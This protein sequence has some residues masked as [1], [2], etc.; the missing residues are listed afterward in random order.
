MGIG[1]V[2]RFKLQDDALVGTLTGAGY[3][4]EFR[5]ERWEGAEAAAA[6]RPRRSR[7]AS[8][9]RRTGSRTWRSSKNSCRR[10]HCNWFD[11]LP[12]EKWKAAVDALWGDFPSLTPVQMVVRMAQ[13]V[14][15]RG[16]AH[17]TFSFTR[18]PEFP[19]CPIAFEQFG[20][21]VFVRG[22]AEAHGDWLGARVVRIGDS[23]IG[24]ALAALDTVRASEN[25]QWKRGNVQLLSRPAVLFGLGLV[26]DAATLPLTLARDG[27]R[28]S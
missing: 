21:E 26:D 6:W 20:D 4:V 14:A 8:W 27:S 10:C 28:T 9:A 22:I 23:P 15:M 3:T 24:Q 1:T 2:V 11:G 18:L 12:E 16:D 17:T 5:A 19:S 7:S 13:L 25:E